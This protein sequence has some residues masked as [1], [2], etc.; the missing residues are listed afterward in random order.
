MSPGWCLTYYHD[1]PDLRGLGTYDCDAVSVAT[2]YR[3]SAFPTLSPGLTTLFD[4]ACLIAF[5]LLAC[6]ETK[7]TN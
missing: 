6:Y 1:N 7:Y 3:Y 4:F 5:G 2:G